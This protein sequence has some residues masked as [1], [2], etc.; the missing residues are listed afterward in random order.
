MKVPAYVLLSGMWVCGAAAAAESVDD[1]YLADMPVVL[2]ASRIQQSPLDAPAPITVIDRQTIEAS[3]F[4]EIKDLMRL[5]PGFQ[6][7]SWSGGS[8]YHGADI[9]ANHG[10]GSAFPRTLL[11]MVD[12]QSVADPIKG[13]VDWEDLPIRIQDIE[14]IEVVR[15]PNQASYGAGAY[16]GV[17]NIITRQPVEDVG[18]LV[19]ISGGRKGFRD[20]YVRYGRAG[21]T[22]DWRLS[23]SDRYFETL[24]GSSPGYPYIRD[25]TRQTLNGSLVHRLDHGNEI[26]A[27]I[28]LST[29]TNDLGHDPDPG[30]YDPQHGSRENMQLLQFAWHASQPGKETYLRYSHNG[31]QQDETVTYLIPTPLSV[32][33]NG[34]TSQDKL[35]YQSYSVLTGSLSGLW[36]ASVQYDQVKSGHFFYGKSRVSD[37]AWQAFGNLDWRFAAD[38]LLHVGAMVEDHSN[39]GTLLS[40]R[41][42]LNYAL[43]PSQSLRFSV[44]RGY[45]V[46]T[47]LESSANEQFLQSGTPIQTGYYSGLP[48]EPEKVKF[49]E[50]GY[51]SRFNDIGLQL[52]SRVYAEHYSQYLNSYRCA[53]PSIAPICAPYSSDI[54][55]PLGIAQIFISGGDTNVNGAEVSADWRN[56]KFGRLLLSYALINIH[57][58]GGFPKANDLDSSAPY[59]SFSLLWSKPFPMRMNASIGYYHVD[60]MMWLGDGDNQPAYDRVDVRL[61]KAFGSPDNPVEIAV[62]AQSVTGSYVEFIKTGDKSSIPV[63]QAFVTLKVGF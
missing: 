50:L 44:G 13:S 63:R 31:H 9:V 15:G 24:D 40:P 29:G 20:E 25:T 32:P 56:P 52:D 2:T 17:I 30:N 45:R 33:F 41:L 16:N 54:I 8:P 61:A 23:A 46:P 3:G 49:A 14:R 1:L 6:V 48:I 7:A 43:T 12:G 19:S 42:A 51:V 35:E 37:S 62:T 10:M 53:A 21:K 28:G 60:Y 57:N 39:T 11:V 55:N 38:W 58:A 47:L 4:T 34:D 26:L 5:V 18:G 36:G 59:G 22:T 27:Y